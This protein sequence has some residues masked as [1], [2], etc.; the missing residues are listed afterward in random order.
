MDF[1]NL[2]HKVLDNCF[3]Q[4]IFNETEF[5]TKQ[6]KAMYFRDVM[7]L[8]FENYHPFIPFPI[9]RSWLI[10]D[11]DF[12]FNGGLTENS[13]SYSGNCTPFMKRTYLL[14]SSQQSGPGHYPQPHRF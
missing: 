9:S 14:P 13:F 8:K 2:W 7:F 11:I 4:E 12:G 5:C 6:T 10:C 3:G 1:K